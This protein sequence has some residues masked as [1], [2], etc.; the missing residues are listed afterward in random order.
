ML[1][2]RRRRKVELI[3]TLGGKCQKCGYNKSVWALDFHHRDKAEKE[4]SIGQKLGLIS[5]K[6]LVVEVA[7]CDLLCRNCHAEVEEAE[8][9]GNPV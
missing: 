7:K 2:A 3:T 6:R 4:F 5:K 8:F 9:F 1:R